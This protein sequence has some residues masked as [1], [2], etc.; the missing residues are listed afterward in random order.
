MCF[1]P[2]DP[3]LPPLHHNPEGFWV[4]QL[5][6]V[7]PRPL[8]QAVV[9]NTL[10][11]MWFAFEPGDARLRAVPV[12]LHRE[13]LLR[14]G[15]PQNLHDEFALPEAVSSISQLRPTA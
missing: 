9:E 13:D 15:H 3:Y 4:Y 11:H 10:V 2:S 5:E 8:V 7:E 12:V 6:E 14:A 1:L